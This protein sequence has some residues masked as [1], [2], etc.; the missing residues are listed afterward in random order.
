M[1]HSIFFHFWQYLDIIVIQFMKG[2]GLSENEFTRRLEPEIKFFCFEKT[3]TEYADLTSRQQEE[4]TMNI[5]NG[6]NFAK[7]VLSTGGCELLILEFSFRRR[8][9]GF[10]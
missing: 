10:S 9:K 1:Y 4:E 2:R 6:I 8:I 5:R 7:K 3:D